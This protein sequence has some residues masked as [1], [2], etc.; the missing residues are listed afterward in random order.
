[1]AVLVEGLSVVVRRNAIEDRVVGGWAEFLKLVPNDTLCTDEEL[2]RVGFLSPPAVG[3]FIDRL[4]QAGLVFLSDKEPVDFSVVD[5][6][7]G[8]TLPTPW[9]QFAHLSLREGEGKVAT[10][11]LFEDAHRGEGLH[12]KSRQLRLATPKGW[13]FEGSLSESFEYRPAKAA[14]DA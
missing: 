14:A 8:P 13:A 3:E 2:V 12:M 6:Q 11:W 9:L 7:T 1:V 4:V 5:Q 10:C